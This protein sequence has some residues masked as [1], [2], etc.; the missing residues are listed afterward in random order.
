MGHGMAGR[1]NQAHPM[2]LH[3]STLSSHHHVITQAMLGHKN[4]YSCC[5]DR[6]PNTAALQQLMY[7]PM[8]CWDTKTRTAAV[9]TEG[10]NTAALQHQRHGCQVYPAACSISSS[11][12]VRQTPT[13]PQED[14]P[15]VLAPSRTFI[16]R[17]G[18]I[19]LASRT[20]AHSASLAVTLA[21]CKGRVGEEQHG[22]NGQHG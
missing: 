8:P 17:P 20:Q 15:T 18:S 3:T 19:F 12:I 6:G 14:L 5:Q 22:M 7:S 9:R 1:H 10:P 16:T 4:T 13:L 2:H 21:W 11:N